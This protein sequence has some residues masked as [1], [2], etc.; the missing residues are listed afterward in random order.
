MDKF[1]EEYLDSFYRIFF[2]WDPNFK[3]ANLLI[4]EDRLTCTCN[5]LG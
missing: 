5:S 2:E 1:T 3:S 4:D